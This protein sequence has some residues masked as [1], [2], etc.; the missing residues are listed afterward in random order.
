[1]TTGD[2]KPESAQHE[3]IDIDELENLL[4][5][6]LEEG[7]GDGSEQQELGLEDLPRKGDGTIDIAALT[8]EQHKVYTA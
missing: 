3:D 4:E 2:Q 7:H 1:M 8:P 6:A 5:T